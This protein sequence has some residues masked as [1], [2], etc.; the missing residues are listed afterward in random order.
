MNRHLKRRQYGKNAAY[1]VCSGRKAYN[2]R[3]DEWSG[4]TEDHL[5]EELGNVWRSVPRPE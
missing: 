5:R 2:C 1:K 3:K 4:L